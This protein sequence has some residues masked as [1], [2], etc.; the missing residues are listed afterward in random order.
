MQYQNEDLNSVKF[1]W[2]SHKV[3]NIHFSKYSCSKI[4]FILA[5][6]I[7]ND[8]QFVVVFVVVVVI[9]IVAVE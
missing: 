2:F 1:L 3:E 9:V 8:C 4:Q 5:S 6:P 7:C